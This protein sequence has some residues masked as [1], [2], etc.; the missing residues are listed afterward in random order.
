MSYR[1]SFTSL[2][3]VFVLLFNVPQAAWAIDAEAW[4]SGQKSGQIR[5]EDTRRGRENGIDVLDFGWGMS[6]PRDAGSGLP[7]GRIQI[8]ALRITKLVDRTSP[9]LANSMAIN[10]KMTNVVIKFYRTS[11][12]GT[13]ENYMTYTLTNAN[14]SDIT[15]IGEKNGTLRE[16]VTFTFQRMQITEPANGISSTIDWEAPVL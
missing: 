5:G 4:I 7:T 2:L 15:V 6:S 8:H 3:S 14:M 10:E 1:T 9:I 16:V 12:M 13:T 11:P